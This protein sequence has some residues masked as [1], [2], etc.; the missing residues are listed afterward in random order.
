MASIESQKITTSICIG[1][2]IANKPSKK[3]EEAISKE[4]FYS[5]N[6]WRVSEWKQLH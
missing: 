4:S 3:I 5:A 2:E 1:T 6:Q